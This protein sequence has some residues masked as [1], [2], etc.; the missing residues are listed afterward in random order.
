MIVIGIRA[1]GWFDVPIRSE[2][3][4][5]DVGIV[6]PTQDG[7]FIVIAWYGEVVINAVCAAAG[8]AWIRWIGEAVGEVVEVVGLLCLACYGLDAPQAGVGVDRVGLG[9]GRWCI[10]MDPIVVVLANIIVQ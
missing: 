3:C 1:Y 5:V 6:V 4:L 9:V 2:V 8:L 7:C 10:G